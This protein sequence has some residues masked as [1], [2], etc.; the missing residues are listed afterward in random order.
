VATTVTTGNGAEKGI[1]LTVEGGP[2]GLVVQAD[3]DKLYL[4]LCN[5]LG[6]ALKFTPSGRRS[7]YRGE[8]GDRLSRF[9]SHGWIAV[10]GA[11]ILFVDDEPDFRRIVESILKKAGS[12]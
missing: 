11:R 2:D 6:N 1:Q 3:P 8:D 5:L 7:F 9:S 12:R 4:V 10:S